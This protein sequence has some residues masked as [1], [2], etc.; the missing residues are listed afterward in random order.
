MYDL[1]PRLQ[2]VFVDNRKCNHSI[3]MFVA[4]HNFWEVTM[5]RRELLRFKVSRPSA[6]PTGVRRSEAINT[7]SIFE[8]LFVALEVGEVGSAERLAI[9]DGDHSVCP[10]NRARVNTAPALSRSAS[11]S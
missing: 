6:I 9:T 2:G 4:V 7:A 8:P 3:S 11:S 5:A 10:N 1:A